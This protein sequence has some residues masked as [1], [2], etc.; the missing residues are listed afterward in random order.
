MAGIPL[1]AVWRFWLSAS[2]IPD[3]SV[4]SRLS[5]AESLSEKSETLLVRLISI[6]R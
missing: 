2:L 3:T 1:F 6:R 5:S 4:I